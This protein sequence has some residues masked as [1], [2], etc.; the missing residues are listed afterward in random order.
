M[1][2]KEIEKSS[3]TEKLKKIAEE[4][5]EVEIDSDKDYEDM[6]KERLEDKSKD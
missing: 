3:I 4:G 6:M 5:E 2:E 1:K